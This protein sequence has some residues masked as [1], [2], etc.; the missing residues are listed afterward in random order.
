MRLP[1][2][3]LAKKLEH[4]YASIYQPEKYAVFREPVDTTKVANYLEKVEKPIDLSKI[5][6]NIALLRYSSLDEFLSDL[7]LMASNAATYN[8]KEHSITK[9]CPGCGDFPDFV[10]AAC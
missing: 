4:V 1:H 9:V 5:R 6:E 2:A 3:T 8:G 10:V 7:K